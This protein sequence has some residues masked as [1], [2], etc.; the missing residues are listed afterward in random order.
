[1]PPENLMDIGA[2]ESETSTSTAKPDENTTP[3]GD[4][5]NDGQSSETNNEDTEQVSRPENVPEKFWDK[6]KNQVRVDEVM[7]SYTEVEKELHKVKG[8]HKAPDEYEVVIPEKYKESIELPDDDPM[9]GAYKEYAKENN[10][11]QSQFT[12]NLGFFV[13]FMSKQAEADLQAE[14]EKFG[15]E[16][17]AKTTIKNVR[18]FLKNRLSPE[19]YEVIVSTTNTFEQ[20]QALDELRKLASVQSPPPNDSN[21]N[22]ESDL[23]EEQLRALMKKPE[24]YDERKRDPDLVKKVEEGFKKLYPPKKG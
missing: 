11:S 10:F 12:A 16:D 18:T 2:D 9:L 3:S 8:E 22:I 6:D 15:G 14:V 17:K 1:M 19:S 24:Y 20:F 4:N 23:T 7:K 5:D 21:A 13:D